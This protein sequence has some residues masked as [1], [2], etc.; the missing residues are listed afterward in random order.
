MIGVVHLGARIESICIRDIDESLHKIEMKCVRI[1]ENSV[2]DS[3]CAD[4]AF[5]GDSTCDFP[6]RIVGSL[7]PLS[8]LLVCRMVHHACHIPSLFRSEH[9]R[10]FTFPWVSL[11]QSI[12]ESI[13]YTT[14]LKNEDPL[15]VYAL[16]EFSTHGPQRGCLVKRFMNASL[17]STTVTA[18]HTKE[19]DVDSIDRALRAKSAAEAKEKAMLKRHSVDFVIDDKMLNHEDLQRVA[20]YLGIPVIP[21][22]S[23]ESLESAVFSVEKGTVSRHVPRNREYRQAF[24]SKALFCRLAEI[25]RAKS[26][27]LSNALKDVSLHVPDEELPV[28]YAAL[29]DAVSAAINGAVS[30]LLTD[31]QILSSR[32]HRAVSGSFGGKEVSRS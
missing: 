21:E 1:V 10:E 22:I 15:T 24:L 30:L 19:I 16:A 29:V 14:I 31:T 13:T 23:K 25:A 2:S 26:P 4:H 11:K 6:T 20:T 28:S 17:S 3:L 5:L 8:A 18:S 9:P 32:A 12:L 27:S 7:S